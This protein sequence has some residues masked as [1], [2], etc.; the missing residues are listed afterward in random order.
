M[1]CQYKKNIHVHPL[2]PIHSEN[3]KFCL[4]IKEILKIILKHSVMR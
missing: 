1:V 3:D 4:N 2:H